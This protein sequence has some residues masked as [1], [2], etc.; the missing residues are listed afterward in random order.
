MAQSAAGGLGMPF[1]LSICAYTNLRRFRCWCC[2][3][4]WYHQRDI[5]I[6]WLKLDFYIETDTLLLRT[7]LDYYYVIVNT[8][9]L[10]IA[11]LSCP[12]PACAA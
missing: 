8:Y 10:K 11:Q 9:L 6:L 4:Q 12:P 3:W 2:R 5:L 1:P 7:H